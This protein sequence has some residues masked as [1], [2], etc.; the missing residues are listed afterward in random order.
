MKTSREFSPADDYGGVISTA[1]SLLFVFFC[2]FITTEPHSLPSIQK[3]FWTAI[4]GEGPIA[5]EEQGGN[6]IV[7]ENAV[8]TSFSLFRC[9]NWLCFFFL[10]YSETHEDAT[11]E[12]CK[13]P[14]PQSCRLCVRLRLA[15]SYRKIWS[16]TDRPTCSSWT[17]Y[18]K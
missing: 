13:R 5:S 14:T 6:D 8:K 11:V 9:E 17:Q 7:V 15:K 2:F 4:G 16:N 1:I 10:C 12:W 18:Q 3:A